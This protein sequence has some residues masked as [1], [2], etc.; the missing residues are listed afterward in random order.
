MTDIATGPKAATR[1]SL[2]PLL[3][4]ARGLC[5]FGDGFAV[6][7][8]S[9]Y[10]TALGYDAVAV[11]IIA[12]ASLLGTALLTFI[13]GWIAPRY[14]LRAPL[15]CGASLMAVTHFRTSNTSS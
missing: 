15:I 8:L 10:M 13:V 1:T 14:D 9:A 7:I 12:T 4:T 2:V 5:G 6:I 11:G 3:Y